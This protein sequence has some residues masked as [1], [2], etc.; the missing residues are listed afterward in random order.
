MRT[1]LSI[2]IF[3]GL[4][5]TILL[6]I[7]VSAEVLNIGNFEHL[8]IDQGL[9]NEQVTSIYQDSKGYMW[10][11]TIDGLNR[12]DG[13]RFKVYNCDLD[14]EDKLS[15]NYI[16]VIQ[17]DSKGNLWIG[18]DCGLDFLVKDTNTIVRIKDL[19]KGK[20][21]LGNLRITSLLRDNN[22]MWVGT[23]N[24]L[25][26]IDIEKSTMDALYHDK[27]IKNSLTNSYIKCIEEDENN[28]L[29]VGTTSGINIVNKKNLSIVYSE[30][31]IK[32]NNLFIYDIEF[33]PSG[34]VWI[35]TK[36]GIFISDIIKD[37]KGISGIKNYENLKENKIK[38]FHDDIGISKNI[39]NNKS[40]LIDS[41]DNMWI[42]SSNGIMKYSLKDE[43]IDMFKKDNRQNNSIT[44]NFVLCFY[45]DRNGT[46]WVGTDKG[47]NILNRGNRFY[48]NYEY[49]K[50]TD[51]LYD[52]NIVSIL[53]NNKYIWVA[54]KY[55]GI[56]I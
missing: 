4:I 17:E 50:K 52:K 26:K 25:I 13:E 31:E 44:S 8:S 29:W 53:M 35:S 10:I 41:K 7:I 43:T 9:S 23:E 36:D 14:N 49:V 34:K 30:N 42:S 24:G 39:Y 54:T 40:L 22:I 1:K 3:L 51:F 5:L 21:N 47:V 19:D 55:D 18:T 6:P 15:S 12:F 33:A 32:N 11:G 2:S 38:D 45:E 46:I 27:S 37:K 28:N 20:F 16:N 48:T 56:Y